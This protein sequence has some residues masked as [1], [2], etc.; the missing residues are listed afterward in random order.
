MTPLET[1]HAVRTLQAQG[2]TLREISHDALHFKAGGEAYD[3]KFPTPR[4]PR[5]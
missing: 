4:W 5:S 2:R 3:I 1:R